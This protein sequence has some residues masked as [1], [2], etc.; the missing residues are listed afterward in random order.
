[1]AGLL[2]D[3]VRL[4]LVLGHAG[5]NLLDN[6]GADGAQEHRRD[7]VGGVAGLAIGA[8]DGDGRSRGHCVGMGVVDGCVVD[9]STR[10]VVVSEATRT[11][12][13]DPNWQGKKKI[14]FRCKFS[15]HRKFWY[16]GPRPSFPPLL[17]LGISCGG[18]LTSYSVVDGLSHA[19][20]H[21]V[22][23][24]SLLG[25]RDAR[26]FGSSFPVPTAAHSYT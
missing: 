20:L 13:L 9:W 14:G 3:R 5:V 11:L 24:K 18:A 17:V 19:S 12:F 26:V 6:V 1:M 25:A 4:A 23:K 10:D 21:L 7:G 2:A 8:V 15:S 22:F 16:S